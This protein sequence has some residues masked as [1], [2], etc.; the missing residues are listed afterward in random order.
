MEKLQK[1]NNFRQASR[2]LSKM[3]FIT[4]RHTKIDKNHVFLSL[5]EYCLK[6]LVSEEDHFLQGDIHHHIYM[7]TDEKFRLVN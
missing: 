5:E 6:L 2:K 3:F 4:V 1:N 7:R